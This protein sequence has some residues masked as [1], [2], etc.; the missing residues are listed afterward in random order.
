MSA[1]AKF[2][3]PSG[4]RLAQ[5]E[6]YSVPI[7]SERPESKISWVSIAFVIAAIA[8]MM[9]V[10]SWQSGPIPTFAGTGLLPENA[11]FSGFLGSGQG[12]NHLVQHAEEH[13]PV[14]GG[15]CIDDLP[16]DLVG[17]G[18]HP[19]EHVRALAG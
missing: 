14:F 3:V 1:P 11:L 18:P 12:L 8:G 15:D 17:V 7:E 19:L 13:L 2:P 16:V 6:A 5:A 9:P 4:D 10:C